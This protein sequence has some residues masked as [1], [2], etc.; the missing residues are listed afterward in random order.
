MTKR[1][2][3]FTT[4]KNRKFAILVPAYNEEKVISKTLYSL[5]SII[6]P[7]RLYDLFVI[8]DNCTDNTAKIAKNLGAIVLE[9]E[10]PVQRGKGYAL[11]WGFDQILSSE[12]KYDAIVVFD[13]DSLISGN[14]LEVMN[15]YLEEGKEVIQSSDLVIPQP[16]VWSSEMIR[17]GFLLYNYVKPLGRKAL[18]L[19]MGLRGNGMCFSTDHLKKHPWE[20]WSR[21]EDLEYGLQ[22]LMKGVVIYFAPEA[23]V[24]AQMPVRAVNA[25]SQRRRWEMGR[26]EIM[27]K[28]ARQFFKETFRRRSLKFLDVLIDLTTPPFAN[29][30]LFVLVMIAVNTL[31]SYTTAMQTHFLILWSSLAIMG[32]LQLLA[33]LFAAKA[34]KDLYK[35]LFYV[36]VYIFWKIKVYIK[37]LFI[38]KDGRWIRTTRDT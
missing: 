36:P 17:I 26:Q 34:D 29:I 30:F 5:F 27:R 31:L 3:N 32:F 22:L 37:T 25:E 8:A 38:G 20:A 19:Q 16:G 4:Q 9:R 24:W 35:S 28:Y 11:R 18:G 15:Y 14:F 10:N 12:K 7:R 21:T 23:C 1:I 6:Y 33:G 13:S 2:K